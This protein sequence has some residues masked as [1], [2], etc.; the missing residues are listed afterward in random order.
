MKKLI[1]SFYF[2]FLFSSTIQAR[3][4]NDLT[5]AYISQLSENT[6]WLKLL[7]YEKGY[8]SPVKSEVTT[9]S[10]FLSEH[11][12]Y[13]PY[14]ELKT[15]ISSM[16]SEHSKTS[17]CRFPA[18]KLWLQKVLPE[19]TEKMPKVSCPEYEEYKQHFSA[20][21]LSLVYASGY[22]GNPASMYGHLLIKLNQTD[23]T[24]LLENTL[25]YGA[26]VP[27]EESKLKYITFGILGGYQA[28]FSSEEFHRHSNTYNESELR[29]L[30]EYELNLSKDDITFLLA[31]HWELKDKTFT[32]YFFKQNCAYQIAKLFELVINR[33]LT[34]T[35][36]A[37][38]MPYDVIAA[39]AD[40][41]IPKNKQLASIRQHE[42][43][44]E[45]FYNKFHQLSHEEQEVVK[46]IADPEG[47][48]A[49]SDFA[50]QSTESQKRIVDTLFDYYSFLEANQDELN[51]EDKE[52][53]RTLLAKRFSLSTEEITW[54]KGT[55]LPPH[56][57]QY[58]SL[59]QF[60]P[61]Y[62]SEQDLGLD[63]RFRASYY[64]LL[65]LDAGRLPYSALSMFDLRLS[66]RDDQ[67]TLKQWDLFNI[68]NLNVS[69]TSLPHDGGY[70]WAIKANIENIDLTCNDCL[71]AGLS[72]G[73]GKSY[74]LK[75]NTAIYAMLDGKIQAPD[76]E[77]G[78][79]KL[80]VKSGLVA[81]ILPS[82]RTSFS[83][84]YHYYLDNTDLHGHSLN[85]EQRFGTSKSWDIRTNLNY[86]G[87]TE[88]GV[89]YG[90]YW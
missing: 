88:F 29:D 46:Q 24:E 20:S 57:A 17:Q 49:F 60:S 64:D 27:P 81:Q 5:D 62:H 12:K 30:W 53:K 56:Q 47:S 58:P 55:T 40:K 77:R 86:D 8:F 10:F 51:P 48:V 89:S 39:I 70:S 19:I 90:Y 7:H 3:T 72:G 66:Y 1:Y 76:R 41:N 71:V 13:S 69:N 65:S 21:S 23:S 15:T 73:I 61:V 9:E 87:A 35:K 44:Q 28:R 43:R 4:A 63:L 75:K 79:M 16:L 34:N 82:W 50:N 31:H 85:W 42:S 54:K 11:G 14:E 52:K 45:A 2:L 6:T 33:P 26:M 80:G 74:E 78:Y 59:F 68:I 25:N 83:A 37:W 67:V 32:Y 18:R 36:K 22:L 84:G 38:V